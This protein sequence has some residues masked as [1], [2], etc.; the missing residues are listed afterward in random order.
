MSPVIKRSVSESHLIAGDDPLSHDHN[1]E[2][3]DDVSGYSVSKLLQEY[4]CALKPTKK[5]ANQSIMNETSNASV[6]SKQTNES[7][8]F[9]LKKKTTTKDVRV[10]HCNTPP[11]TDE[12]MSGVK[13]SEETNVTSAA[14]S[15]VKTFSFSTNDLSSMNKSLYVSTGEHESPKTNGLSD[16]VS[17]GSVTPNSIQGMDKWCS[18]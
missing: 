15:I 1:S 18:S 12:Q 9:E 6:E 3:T 7:I 5:P 16:T 4:R 13:G 17:I 10:G 8:K 14:S 11:H 2:N